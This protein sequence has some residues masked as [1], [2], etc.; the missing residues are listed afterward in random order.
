MQRYN[1]FLFEKENKLARVW[2]TYAVIPERFR[3]VYIV[4][5]ERPIDEVFFEIREKVESKIL[6]KEE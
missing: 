1:L 2:E 3:N 4:N 6:K 5:G